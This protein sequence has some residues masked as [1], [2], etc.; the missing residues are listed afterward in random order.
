MPAR[1]KI[2]ELNDL[3]IRTKDGAVTYVRD[4]AFVHDG[5]PPQTNIVRVNGRRAVL[6]TI[7]KTGAASTLNIVNAIKDAPAAASA[8]CCPTGATVDA[9]RRSVR[10]R[11]G[12]G[13]GAS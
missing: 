3:P 13:A 9:D 4:V 7:Q 11:A 5:H 6:M 12:R 8:S 10:V 1:T 2:E